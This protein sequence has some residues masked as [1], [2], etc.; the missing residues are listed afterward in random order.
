MSD[1]VKTLQSMATRVPKIILQRAEEM[2]PALKE[3]MVSYLCLCRRKDFITLV[4]RFRWQKSCK[5]LI[6]CVLNHT[7]VVVHIKGVRMFMVPLSESVR[8]GLEYKSD[9]DW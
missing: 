1:L 3:G 4:A 9:A 6:S 5:F 8:M 2:Y 7:K